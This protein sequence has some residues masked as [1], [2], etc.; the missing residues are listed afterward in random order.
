MINSLLYPGMDKCRECI[1]YNITNTYTCDIYNNYIA[2]HSVKKI[3]KYNICNMLNAQE[4]KYDNDV[5]YTISLGCLF[6]LPFDKKLWKLIDAK[7]NK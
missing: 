6:Y 7:V 2:T 3:T 1:Y 5:Y 4:L